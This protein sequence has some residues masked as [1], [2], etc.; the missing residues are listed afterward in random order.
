MYVLCMY[1]HTH[2]HIYMCVYAEKNGVNIFA[3]YI[4]INI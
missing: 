4:N 1:S 2:T 3:K